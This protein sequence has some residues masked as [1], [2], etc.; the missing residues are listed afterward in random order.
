MPLLR[1][2]SS[3]EHG[4]KVITIAI[5]ILLLWGVKIAPDIKKGVDSIS[6][7]GFICSMN[8]FT[9]GVTCRVIHG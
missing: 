5:L 8:I 7:S 1:L 2:R 9:C 3:V 4:F 6:N